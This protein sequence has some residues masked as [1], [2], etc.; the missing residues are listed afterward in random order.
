MRSCY[1]EIAK[2][3]NGSRA[4]ARL[5][6]ARPTTL[7]ERRADLAD[8]VRKLQGLGA[9]SGGTQRYRAHTKDKARQKQQK[10]AAGGVWAGWALDPPVMR[11]GGVAAVQAASLC[12]G[13]HGAQAK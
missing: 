10:R 3:A 8:N 2:E 6:A 9:V 11:L 13:A 4:G 12:A 7:G 5:G 1:A